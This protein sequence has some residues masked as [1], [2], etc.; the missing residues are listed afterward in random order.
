MIVD[1]ML[2]LISWNSRRDDDGDS[3]SDDASDEDNYDYLRDEEKKKLVER[4]HLYLGT[5]E[6]SQIGKWFY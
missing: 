5:K 2:H 6:V 4:Y 1:Q 3:Q